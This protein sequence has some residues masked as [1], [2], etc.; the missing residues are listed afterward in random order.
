[1]SSI[2]KSLDRRTGIIYVYSSESY[3]DKEKKSP[4]NRRKLIGKI[5][6]ETGEMVPTSGTRRKAMERKAEEAKTRLINDIHGLE[7]D[8]SALL[9]SSINKVYSKPS[10]F[11]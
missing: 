3:W 10:V 2:V 11:Q 7:E 5:D 8:K 1:M 6:P 4:R 9:S